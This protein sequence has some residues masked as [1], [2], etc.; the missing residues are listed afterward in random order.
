[1]LW[2][3]RARGTREGWKLRGASSPLDEEVALPVQSVAGKQQNSVCTRLPLN[4]STQ[5]VSALLP[6]GDVSLSLKKR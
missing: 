5:M 3:G 6:L 2:R 4:G 1:M